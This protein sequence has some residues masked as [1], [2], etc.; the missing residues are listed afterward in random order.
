PDNGFAWRGAQ[1]ERG[2][3]RALA[4]AI[5]SP[6]RVG[7]Q[8]EPERTPPDHADRLARLHLPPHAAIRADLMITPATGKR[9]VFDVRTVNGLCASGLSAYASAAKHLDAIE[10]HKHRKYAA[11]YTNF[12]SF[13]VTLAGAVTDAS[14]LALRA[15]TAEA[16]KVCDW[17]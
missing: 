13:V 11:Y 4:A 6:L 12:K 2:L 8:P 7:Y 14:H 3:A 5:P 10:R 15:V 1:L 9:F 17:A 16:A